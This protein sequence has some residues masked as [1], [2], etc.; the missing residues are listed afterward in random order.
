MIKKHVVPTSIRRI[1]GGG[2]REELLD[3]DLDL[4]CWPELVRV[5]PG[6]EYSAV[7][8]F[9]E[10]IMLQKETAEPIREADSLADRIVD[11]EADRG[12]CTV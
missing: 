7:A 4:V 5:R 3:E 11:T 8:S 6:Q 10:Y 1:R 9:C 12:G 2:K